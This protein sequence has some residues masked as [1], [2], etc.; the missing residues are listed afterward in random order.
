MHRSYGHGP[1]RYSY[2]PPPFFHSPTHVN[3]HQYHPHSAF[4]PVVMPITPLQKATPRRLER[5]DSST[6]CFHK[7]QQFQKIM[8]ANKMQEIDHHNQ[9]LSYLAHQNKGELIPEIKLPKRVLF[10]MNI[11]GNEFRHLIV[12]S[13]HFGIE[14]SEKIPLIHSKAEC[15]ISLADRV[16]GKEADFT[17]IMIDGPAEKIEDASLEFLSL[18]PLHIG[19]HLAGLK[20][21]ITSRD[22][23]TKL[24]EWMDTGAYEY[25]NISFHF[26]KD[27]SKNS[28]QYKYVVLREARQKS[29]DLIN[30]AFAFSKL[31]LKKPLINEFSA[32]YRLP[33]ADKIWFL[34][35][36]EELVRAI[37]DK[38]ET[39][40]KYANNTVGGTMDFSIFGTPRAI[41][42][43]E[44]LLRNVSQVS[45][46]F[47][48]DD[49]DLKD[50]IR[51]H[52]KNYTKLNDK[53]LVLISYDISDYQNP[54]KNGEKLIRHSITIKTSYENRHRL[55][56]THR[57]LLKPY[58]TKYWPINK[59]E[60]KHEEPLFAYQLRRIIMLLAKVS[61]EGSRTPI[62][63]NDGRRTPIN[64]GSRTPIKM[65]T[66]EQRTRSN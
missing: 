31:A 19:M 11:H 38:T 5:H 47:D 45:L 55:Y 8:A 39:T 44:T 62:K 21:E 40:I 7:N 65:K 33:F 32:G 46:Q 1:P 60:F 49:D 6:D 15:R 9:L 42:S 30:A 36:D 23:R 58:L 48:V 34:G 3:H 25:S 59:I 29:E 57:D 20:D 52:R 35:V 66:N 24:I 64:E 63:T 41:I 53:N 16:M 12:Q 43:A 51:D 37:C 50:P 54:S 10:T 18:L 13:Q 27:E 61:N 56:I 26:V 28:G 17:K 14:I 22:L 4:I 2:Q